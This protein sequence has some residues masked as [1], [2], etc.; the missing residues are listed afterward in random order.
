MRRQYV[1][2]GASK[3][4]MAAMQVSTVV[5]VTDDVKVNVA[6]LSKTFE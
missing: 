2:F 1:V 5:R 4:L 6:V 3:M